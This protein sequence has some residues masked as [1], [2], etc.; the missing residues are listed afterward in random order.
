[1][2]IFCYG[3]NMSTDRITE[4]CSSST[5]ISIAKVKGYKLLFNK[6]SKDKSGK[7]N[8]IYTGDDSLVWGVIFDISENQKPL[9]DKAEG[10]GKGYNEYKLK[11]ISDLE[12]EIECVC[13][14]A[15]E[16]KYL[17]NNLKPYDWYKEYCLTGAKQHNLPQDYI[18]TIEKI[19]HYD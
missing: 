15:T 11:V 5:F 9:L 14:I 16:E 8:L 12:E 4:R 2:K 7:A 18:L 3:S 17:D 10:L 1:M 6:I 19:K 13:Y